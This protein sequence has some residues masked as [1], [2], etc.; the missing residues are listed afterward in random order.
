MREERGEGLTKM[1][2]ATRNQP[3]PSLTSR[4]AGKTPSSTKR[5]NDARENQ[6]APY[7]LKAVAPNVLLLR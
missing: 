7:V 5:M 3:R 1:K 4:E 6:K 2:K